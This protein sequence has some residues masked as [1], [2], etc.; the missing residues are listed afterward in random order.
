[1]EVT[2]GS[3]IKHAW[4]AFLN[5]DPTRNFRNMGIG[6]SYRPDRIRLSR[7]NERSIVTS[8]YNRIALDAAAI[9]I[10]HV[11]LDE[12][13][14][15]LSVINSELN[16]CLSLESNIDQTGRAFI[17]DVVMSMMDEG[18]VAL[19]PVD[20]TDDP[21]ITGAYD[22]NSLRTGKILEW[23]PQ[24]IKTLVYN[25]RIGRKEDIE[26]AKKAVAI[27]ENPLY[28][29]MNEPNSTMQRLVRKLNLLD[30]VD[31]Q[32]SSGK[33]DLIIQLPYVIKTEARRQQANNR[34]QDI[35][36][37][38]SGSKYGI[39]YTDGTERITQ[40][41]RPVE[42]NLMK[43]IEYLT[44]MLY[45][46]LGITQSILDGTADDKTMLN[47]YNRTIEPIV[48][49]IVD[50]MKR[51]FLTKTA[52]SQFQ[53][54]LFFRDPFKLVP[55]SEIS[56]IA[57]KFTRN[58][59]MTSNEI[60]QIIGLRPS[61]DPKADELRNKNLNQSA[62]DISDEE[63]SDEGPQQ[64]GMTR[65]EYDS[66]IKDLD[67]LDA[68][69]DELEE[70]LDADEDLKH[71]ASQYYD[72]VKAHEYYLKNRELKSRKSTAKLNDAGKNAA[73]YVKEQLTSERKGK[74]KTHKD[75]TDSQ[76]ES[77]RNRKKA[78]VEAHKNAM[79]GKI[80][81][82]RELLKDMSKE[83]K[84]SKKERIYN[85]IGSLREDNKK[86]RL[87]LQ[88]EFKSSSDSLRSDHK[89]ERTRLKEEYDEKYIQELDKIRSDSTFKRAPKKKSSKSDTKSKLA[90]YMIKG[91]NSK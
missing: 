33:L 62:E 83:E 1:M 82:L 36:D 64:E 22:I 71:Y 37:Q 16:K 69:L 42:N 25:E 53:S 76:I 77:L 13:D 66:A 79:Q 35:E 23:Y 4:N 5:K 3:R 56:E 90:K 18:C 28:A 45:S 26:L 63:A 50:E 52:R 70:E 40:L 48:S 49:A 12:N 61:D 88:E 6:Y 24:H 46:Q 39:A 73:Q 30:A 32:S 58:E 67:D 9:S 54:I 11:R 27:V 91:G 89:E 68:Q 17:Q 80:D 15:F 21:E 14:R 34:R 59:I 72:P 60:R 84:A 47:Y 7:G 29:V 38:L 78:N 10:Q 19:V 43:Q 65:E 87:R 8:V 75:Q 41:N 85:L 20:T 57:D 51:K 74:V 55:V 44:S 2:F 81:D 86:E 31:E